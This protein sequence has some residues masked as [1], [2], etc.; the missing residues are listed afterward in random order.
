M[1]W[2]TRVMRPRGMRPALPSATQSNV[3][4]ISGQWG[5][6]PLPLMSEATVNGLPAM[7]RGCNMIANAIASMAP[8]RLLG[9]DGFLV[10][11]DLT[12]NVL[13]RPN[14]TFGTFDFFAMAMHMCIKRGNFL[15]LK[16]DFDS[17]GYPQQLVPVPTGFWVAYYDGAGFLVYNVRGTPYSAEEVVHI[18][19]NALPN[20]VM[21]IGVVE[22]FR[23]SIG[24]ALDQQNF[25]ADTY[26]SG[27][28][29]A[30]VINLDL[31][32]VDANQAAFV[33]SQWLT[34]HSG[35]RAPAVL[36]STMHFAPISW[37]PEDMQFLEARQFT[38]GECAHMLNMDPTD[39][40]AALLGDS[41]T[42][43]NIEQRQV[44]RTVDTYAPWMRRF[45]DAWS[46]LVPS[47]SKA[48]MVPANLLRTDSKTQA[49]VDQLQIGTGTRTV[50][51]LRQ[52]D[53]L[54][55]LPPPPPAPD[56]PPPGPKPIPDTDL[57]QVPVKVKE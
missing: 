21:G 16:A 26:R 8:M 46:D 52:R 10:D 42:Y 11:E 56:G 51:E 18:R 24:Q 37:S 17:N 34:N 40:G 3:Y 12:P 6:I 47:T 45:E 36:P 35:G 33:Q 19:A 5:A 32:E 39:L 15:A 2:L 49:E 55:P 13:L 23:R 1:S 4:P 9:P 41:M 30:G 31:P 38:V 7:S 44:Q 57:E 54:K 50:K 14:S 27:S 43:A 25:A 22:Q 28:V 29:P 20:Q 53:G 48:K